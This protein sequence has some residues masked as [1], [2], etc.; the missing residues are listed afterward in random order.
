[1]T[2]IEIMALIVA[3][4]A[5]VKLVVALISPKSWLGS[6]TKTAWSNP[7]LTTIGSLVLAAVALFYLLE[8]LTI[9]QIFAAMFFLMLLM[10]MGF[11][12]YA[13]DMLALE[14]KMLKDRD[15]VKRGWLSIIVWGILV[16]WVLYA[17][18]A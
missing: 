9:V 3:V 16:I 18:F 2:P 8:E 4:F 15:V 17:L 11:A 10:V 13:K 6:V 7:T 5:G 12:P 14:D 1:M